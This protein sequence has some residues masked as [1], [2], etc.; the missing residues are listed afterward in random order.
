[1][2]FI[3]DPHFLLSLGITSDVANYLN[4]KMLSLL[5]VFLHKVTLEIV[6]M[7]GFFWAILILNILPNQETICFE[8]IFRKCDE[9]ASRRVSVH[10]T[11]TVLIS[12][13][14]FRLSSF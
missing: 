7:T 11:G 10:P 3:N 6:S 2:Q 5:S 13:D 8:F 4:T 9:H 14:V 12:F 1:M